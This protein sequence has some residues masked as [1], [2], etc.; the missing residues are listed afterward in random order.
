MEPLLTAQQMR[1]ADRHAIEQLAIP[2]I[3]LMEHA[4]LALVTALTERFG[5]AL[6]Q[7]KGIVLVGPG[8]NGADA[9]ACVRLLHERGCHNIFVILVEGASPTQLSDMA[10]LQLSIL[11]KLGIVT[12]VELDR[13]LVEACDW[14]VDGIFGTG[15]KREITGSCL[16][17][18][19]LVNEYAEKKWILA[20]D[21][22]S[23]LDSDTGQIHGIAIKA[24]HTTTFGFLKRGLVTAVGA[25]YVGTIN[26]APIQIPRL[27]P[28]PIDTFLYT[29]KDAARLPLRKKAS[30]KG[31]FGHV[32]ILAGEESKEGACLLSALGALRA[33]AGLVTLVGDHKV[34]ER[35]RPRM[36]AEVMSADWNENLFKDPKKTSL[37]LGPGLGL[38]HWSLIES[39]LE[40][41]IPLVIDADAITILSQ[42]RKEAQKLLKKRKKGITVLTPHPKEA[43]RLLNCSVEEVE[44]DRF[45]AI[46]KLCEEYSSYFILKGKGSCIRSPDGPTFIIQEGDS[47]LAKGGSGDLLSGILGT[48]L[49]QSLSPQQAVLLSVYLHG[50]ASELLTQKRGTSR[51][52]LPSEI[53]DE[54]VEA[55]RELESCIG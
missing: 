50:R 2:E 9:L 21:I 20:V 36:P 52:S 47:G 45:E 5:K 24:S 35:L 34:L 27:L 8:N 49:V 55:I 48:M 12:G 1:S 6:P 10:A 31:D 25:D 18:I 53:A 22:P 16:N 33:G 26:L 46:R 41:D 28:F 23:G 30:H 14:I 19:Q 44:K 11:G 43:A 38:G 40:K 42:N 15:L 29:S 51:C 7:T 37:V 32:W 17:A 39:L 13:E 4:A 3:I 54:L